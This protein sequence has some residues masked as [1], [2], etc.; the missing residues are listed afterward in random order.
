MTDITFECHS[1]KELQGARAGVGAFKV[2]VL[3]ASHDY[4]HV[5]CAISKWQNKKPTCWLADEIVKSGEQPTK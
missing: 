3:N 5:R 4:L 2:L 1:C